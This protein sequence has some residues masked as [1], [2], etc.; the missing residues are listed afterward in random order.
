MTVLCKPIGRGRWTPM[1]LTY[2]GPQLAPFTVRLGERFTMGG[3]TWRVCEV[4]P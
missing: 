3:V 1:L 4:R 2:A